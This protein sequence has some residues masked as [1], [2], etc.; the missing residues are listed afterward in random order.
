MLGDAAGRGCGL[1]LQLGHG[2]HQRHRRRGKA[3][4]PSGHAIGF[5]H[6][7]QGQHAVRQVGREAGDGAEFE[8]VIGQMLVEV[9]RDHH[10]LRVP[11]DDIGEGAQLVR[12]VAHAGRVRRA[13]DDDPARTRGDRRL[14]PFGRQFQPVGK[15][16]GKKDGRAAGH[17]GDAGEA[18]PVGGRNDHLVAGLHRRHQRVEQHLLAAGADR[19]VGG[20][21]VEPVLAAEFLGDRILQLGDAVDLGIAGVAVM[22]GA[23]RGLLHMR[24]GLE[25][26]LADGKAD[27]IAPGGAKV[28]RQRRDRHRRRGRDARHPVGEGD[29]RG[30]RPGTRPGVRCFG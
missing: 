9:V 4:A 30:I 29:G 8:P 19:D 24:R 7:V 26:G 25:I 20:A 21:D 2:F 18:D 13:V 22:D 15:A 17:L 23:D 10:Q 6:P 14:E 1:R 16:A 28:E 5:R 11:A 27:D 3:D 12:A